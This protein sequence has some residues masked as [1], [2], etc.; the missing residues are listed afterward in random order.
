M[1]SRVQVSDLAE[2]LAPID[3]ELALVEAR[4]RRT[5]AGEEDP[6]RGIIGD[7]LDSGGK[8]IRPALTILT[9]RF[10]DADRDSVISIAASVELFHTATLVHD[11][12]I[13]G[14]DLRRG[15]PTVNH[16][17]DDQVAILVGDNLFSRA[18]SLTAEVD[19]P[20]L[21]RLLAEAVLTISSGELHEALRDGQNIPSSEEYHVRIERKTAS[22]FAA[23]CEAGAILARAPE[24]EA[25]ALREFGRDLGI[26]FQIVDD[27]LDFAGQEEI[28]GKPIG[29]DLRQGTVTLPTIYYLRDH[30]LSDEL[31]EMVLR[32]DGARLDGLVDAIRNSPSIDDCM[33]EARSHSEAAKRALEHLPPGS[34]RQVLSDLAD[35]LLVRER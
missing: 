21:I 25:S 6:L 3:E 19:N 14:S 16:S 15:R 34:N 2:L 28:L 13:D 20:D 30:P 23:S 24:A 18:A 1:K 33:A 31:G 12:A 29:S 17:W 35:A 5:Y 11:D 32:G 4:M 26:A 8:R 22:L 7:L 9:S 27:V 10:H